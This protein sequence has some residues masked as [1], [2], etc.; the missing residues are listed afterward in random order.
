MLIATLHFRSAEDMITFLE[1]QTPDVQDISFSQKFKPDKRIKD[2]ITSDL[3]QLL[4]DIFIESRKT[5][6]YLFI[7]VLENVTKAYLEIMNREW[8]LVITVDPKT[9]L[10]PLIRMVGQYKYSFEL[11][12]D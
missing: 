1:E 7:E 12:V 6:Y 2:Q 5:E 3:R 4:F 9:Q 10:Y 11:K 8:D